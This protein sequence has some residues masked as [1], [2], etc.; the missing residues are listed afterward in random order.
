MS[1]STSPSAEQSDFTD[2]LIL[3]DEKIV[4]TV[5]VLRQRISERFPEAGLSTLCGQLLN[6]ARKAAER[7][8]WIESPIVWIRLTGL[9]L[10]ATMI[11]ILFAL[12]MHA[13]NSGDEEK[14]SFTEFIQAFEAGVNEAIFIAAALYFLVSLET[15]IKR[16]RALA[17][18]H[19]L[20]SI[21][22]IIDMHQLTKDPERL[23]GNLERTASSP[24]LAM[25][26]QQLNRY[27]DYCSE[28]LS[29]TGKI[30]A[31][32]VRKFDDAVAVAAVSEVEQLTTGLSR[33]IWQKIM[34][35]REMSEDFRDHQ[36][37]PTEQPSPPTEQP[38]PTTSEPAP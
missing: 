38:S 15:R 7:S 28:M 19:E 16:R 24:K 36:P 12:G 34:L 37:P 27:L 6:V 32:Y 3:Q 29:L 30:A 5:D 8:A 9:L 20:R 4:A 31:L 21:A 18:V 10:A 2:S 35:L 11:L 22:H 33:K 1:E 14:L 23:I 13:F 26:P 25:T 17:A